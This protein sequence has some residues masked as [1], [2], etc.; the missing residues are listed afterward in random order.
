MSTSNF[1]L[2]QEYTLV[3]FLL[4]V[5]QSI[6]EGWT[7]DLNTIQNYPQQVGPVFMAGMVRE[8]VEAVKSVQATQVSQYLQD[9]ALTAQE[10]TQGVQGTQK[11]GYKKSS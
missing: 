11:R 2:V 6:K 9:S 1:N 10:P 5:Q 3:D 7:F 4:K 8:P